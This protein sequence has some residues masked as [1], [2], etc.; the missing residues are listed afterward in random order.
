MAVH[1]YCY[2]GVVPRQVDHEQRRCEIIY[3]VWAVI[4]ERGIEAVTMRGVAGEAGVSVGR[5]QHYFPS[6][7]ELVR[8]ACRAMVEGA[9]Q[10]F[11][12]QTADADP[13]SALR[14]LVTHV[15]PADDAFRV[16]TA[17]WYSFVAKSID[18]PAI[19]RIL[20]EAKRAAAELAVQL[21]K[22]AKGQGRLQTHLD[23]EGVARQLLTMADGLAMA[24]L[25][26]H[27]SAA[28]GLAVIAHFMSSITKDDYTDRGRLTRS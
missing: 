22:E 11:Q 27:L 12:A 5:I 3:A 23:E 8:A 20:S 21:L 6:K 28:E 15:I 19:A 7:E 24:V 26:G 4:A 9:Y 14:E 18:D 17:V 25:I 16:G 10:R 2:S 13:L 1:V